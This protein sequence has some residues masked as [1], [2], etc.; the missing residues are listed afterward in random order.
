M[1]VRG[2][3]DLLCSK[4]DVVP[5]FP[6]AFCLF[7]TRESSDSRCMAEGCPGHLLS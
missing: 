5:S 3:T 4:V 1:F 6:I 2:R 7:T